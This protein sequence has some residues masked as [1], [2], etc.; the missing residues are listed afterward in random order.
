MAYIRNYTLG[1]TY[2]NLNSNNST[3]ML[4]ADLVEHRQNIT[5]L[6]KERERFLSLDN[7]LIAI[8]SGVIGTLDRT[9]LSVVT[10]FSGGY[11]SVST[12]RGLLQLSGTEIE[13]DLLESCI[14]RLYRYQ[15]IDITFF[16]DTEISTSFENAILSLTPFGSYCAKNSIGINHKYNPRDYTSSTTDQIKTCATTAHIICNFLARS[17]IEYFVIRPTLFSKSKS[18]KDGGV[19]RPSATVTIRGNKVHL[20]SPRRTSSEIWMSD[21]LGKLI[22]YKLVYGNNLPTIVIT[23]EDKEASHECYQFLSKNE[24]EADALVFSDNYSQNEDFANSFYIFK[25]GSLQNYPFE[26]F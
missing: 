5:A 25:D 11:V 18:P 3:F 20:E 7:V 21:L 6:T 17:E 1:A 23:C 8:E 13:Q 2:R 4:D 22:R 14:D 19:I 26:N 9:I 12:L 15:L 24:F 10:A 16:S